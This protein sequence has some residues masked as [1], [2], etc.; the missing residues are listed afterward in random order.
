MEKAKIR[1]IHSVSVADVL[2]IAFFLFMALLTIFPMWYVLVGSF[3][4]GADY[5]RGGVVFWPRVW[6]L[7]NYQY[8]LM[9]IRIWK[10]YGITIA[11]TVLGTGLHVVITFIVAYAMSI[12]LLKFRN[13]YYGIMIVTMF[14]GGGMIPYYVW[15]SMTGLL[16]TFWVYVIPKMFSVYNMLVFLAF[17]RSLP[18]E[19]REAATL[20]GAGEYRICMQIMLPCCKPV[21]ATIV[22]WQVVSHWNNYFDSMYYVMNG[23]LYTLQ[24]VL[25]I[26]I[27]ELSVQDNDLIPPTVLETLTPTVISYAA[28]IVTIL[29]VLFVY[30]FLQKQ[31]AKGFMLGSLKG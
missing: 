28:I 16:D 5:T 30:P 18:G 20:D 9:D 6:S 10:A 13:V 22:L 15:L 8:V 3:S 1:K 4:E 19:L 21:I 7:A 23:D 12:P 24:Y 14:F 25:K 26:I 2:I 29:P 27:N 17:I 31:F 11:R